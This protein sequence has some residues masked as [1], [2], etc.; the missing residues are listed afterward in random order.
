MSSMDRRCAL[1]TLASTG[2]V[3][4]GCGGDDSSGTDADTD[5]DEGG[6]A[7]AE[8]DPCTA[9]PG[10]IVGA[11]TDFAVGTWTLVQL[12]FA[13]I[14]IV[15]QDTNGFFAYSAICT[16]QGCIIGQPSANGSTLCPCHFSQFDGNGNVTAGPAPSP[17]QH[18]EVTVCNG[19]VYVNS[20]K[21][22]N[23]TTRTPPQ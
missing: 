2:A 23:E 5:A 3:L 4:V 16:H 19:N 10:K 15:A 17:L 1:C 20:S 21:S 14:F 6:D 8:T 22:V 18:F 13:H 7:P 12:D 9:T 11:E